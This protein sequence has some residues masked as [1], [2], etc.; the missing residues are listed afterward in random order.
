VPDPNDDKP[1]GPENSTKVT[2]D[3]QDITFFTPKQCVNPGGKVRVRVTSKTKKKI[4]KGKGR[5][6]ILFVD[7]FMDTT[8]GFTD[9][10]KAFRTKLST[11]GLKPGT[12]HT[13]KAR[14][15]LQQLTGKKKTFK[16]TLTAQ[17]SI[18]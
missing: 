18:C 15:K 3:D 6:K 14:V 7:F 4:A 13:A 9:K 11:K 10:K 2:A 1:V 8:L 5:S 16:K 12:K 17:I